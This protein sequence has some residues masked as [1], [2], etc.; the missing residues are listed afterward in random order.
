MRAG[1]DR[2]GPEGCALTSAAMV[3][4]YYGADVNP[5]TL[6]ACLGAFAEDIYWSQA[7]GCVNGK[8]TGANALDFSWPNLDQI[9][10]KGKP[11]IV[12]LL[13]GQAGSHFVVVTSGGGGDASNYT[14]HRPVGRIDE[15]HPPDADQPGLQPA[16]DSHV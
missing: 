5:G 9:L 6:N 10:S 4:N 13:G 8:V 1:G 12:G 7:V 2:I 15:S 16:L 3:L 14:D 11:A